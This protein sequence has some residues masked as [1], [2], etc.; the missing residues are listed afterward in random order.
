MT[1][2]QAALPNPSTAAAKEKTKFAADFA[3]EAVY[4]RG[5]DGGRVASQLMRTDRVEEHGYG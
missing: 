1:F 3:A 4:R 2:L 5:G